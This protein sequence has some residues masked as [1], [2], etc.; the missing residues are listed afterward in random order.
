VEVIKAAWSEDMAKNFHLSPFKRIHIDPKTK[1]ETRVYD[2]VYTSD[3][4][5]EAHDDLQ[6]QPN[7]PGCQLEKVIAGL[8][9]WSNSTHLTSFGT[10][11]VWPLYLYFANLSKYTRA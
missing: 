4:W 9:F 2:E 10:A 1:V 11:K 6:K 5:I 3:A 7:E 8:M